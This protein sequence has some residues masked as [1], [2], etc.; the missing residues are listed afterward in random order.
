VGLSERGLR[1]WPSAGRLMDLFC[2]RPKL[3][4]EVTAV[5]ELHGED[6]L[7]SLMISSTDGFG[8]INRKVSFPLEEGAITRGDIQD[9]LNWKAC[10]VLRWIQLAAIASVLAAVFSAM[11]LL[12]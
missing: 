4:P 5:C 11:A 8:G 7:R 1:S 9:F 2:R 12:H 10:K 6:A 3:S